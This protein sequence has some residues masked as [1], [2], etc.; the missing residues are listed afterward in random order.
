MCRAVLGCT[1]KSYSSASSGVVAS[2]SQMEGCVRLSCTQSYRSASSGVVASG[3]QMEAA[4][5]CHAF[6]L[7]VLFHQSLTGFSEGDSVVQLLES[8]ARLCKSIC[9]PPHFLPG[10]SEQGPGGL[11]PPLSVLTAH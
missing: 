1:L 10:H 7:I 8:A 3:R 11:P 4:L 2:D 9:Q 6:S 5:G